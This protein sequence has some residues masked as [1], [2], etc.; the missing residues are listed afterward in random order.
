MIFIDRIRNVLIKIIIAFL[1][2]LFLLFISEFAINRTTI[3]IADLVTQNKTYNT[4]LADEPYP[5]PTIEN[6]AQD[7][8]GATL[9]YPPPDNEQSNTDNLPTLPPIPTDRIVAVYSTGE[10]SDINIDI[11]DYPDIVQING[12]SNVRSTDVPRIF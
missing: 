5:P 7:N 2:C 4:A 10:F 8:S 12:D 3:I 11:S 9:P 6:P 1:V